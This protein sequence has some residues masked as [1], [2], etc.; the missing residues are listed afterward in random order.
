MALTKDTPRQYVG[1]CQANYYPVAGSQNIYQG[2]ALGKSTLGV[3]SEFTDGDVFAGFATDAIT[4]GADPK[5]A[6]ILVN[7]KGGIRLTV[8][9]SGASAVDAVVYA[10]DDNTFSVTDSGSDT[11][12]GV[13]RRQHAA[14]GTEWTVDFKAAGIQ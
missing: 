1:E 2:A 8:A 4:T 7:V 10:T 6:Q 14:N 12:I 13:L 9:A 5:G 3:V 11:A